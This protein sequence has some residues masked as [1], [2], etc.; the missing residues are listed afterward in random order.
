MKY[1]ITFWFQNF[2]SFI[3]IAWHNS[4]IDECNHDFG[5]C[6]NSLG[7]YWLRIKRKTK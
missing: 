1:K 6:E 5:C 4:Y 7:K 2:L 3:G